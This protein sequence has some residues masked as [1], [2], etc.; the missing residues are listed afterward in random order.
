MNRLLAIALCTLLSCVY[1]IV[2]HAADFSTN[3]HILSFGRE[4]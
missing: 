2:G 4:P 1:S 3:Q